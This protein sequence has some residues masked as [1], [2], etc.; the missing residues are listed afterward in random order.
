[1]TCNAENN[2]CSGNVNQNPLVCQQDI[3]GIPRCMMKGGQGCADAGSRSGQACATSVDCCGLPCV[4]NPSF[5]PDAGASVP[6]FICG[7]TC[8]GTGGACTT[9]ADCCPGLPCTMTPGSTRGTCGGQPTPDGGIT[10]PPDGSTPDAG[11][12]APPPGCAQYGQ[13]CTTSAECCDGVPCTGGRC[14]I[15]VN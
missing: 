3:L 1:M 14:V 13:Q 4:P 11:T 7:G 15:I 2:C 5:T 6:A 12:D 8:V 10:P 9:G